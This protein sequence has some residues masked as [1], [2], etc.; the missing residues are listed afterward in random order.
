MKKPN[1]SFQKSIENQVFDILM[2]EGKCLLAAAP[3]SGKSKM[4]A[5]IIKKFKASRKTASK[6]VAFTHGSKVLQKQF[7]SDL[8]KQGVICGEMHDG[9]NITVTLPHATRKYKGKVDLLIVDEAHHFYYANMI[10]NFIKVVKPKYIL[11]MTGSPGIF[12][13]TNDFKAVY[14]PTE[15]LLSKSVISNPDIRLESFNLDIDLN[16]YEDRTDSLERSFRFKQSQVSKAIRSIDKYKGK[17]IIVC[18]DI[19]HL[20]Q[21]EKVLDK[22]NHSYVS[23][24]YKNDVSSSNIERFRSDKTRY[25]LV[26]K[27][28]VLGFSMDNL[29]NIIDFSGSM[30]I[31]FLFQLINRVTRLGFGKKFIKICEKNMFDFHYLSLNSACALVIREYY[32]TYTPQTVK[33]MQ[34]PIDK[35]VLR[36]IKKNARKENKTSIGAFTVDIEFLIKNHENKNIYAYSS[37]KKIRSLYASNTSFYTI[38]SASK[39]AKSCKTP[40]DFKRKHNGAYQFMLRDARE[41]YY[42]IFPTEEKLVDKE[43]A[44]RAAKSFSSRSEMMGSNKGRVVYNAI[45]RYKALGDLDK[46]F[47]DKK[48]HHKKSLSD[49]LELA[50]SFGDRNKFMKKHS[51]YYTKLRASPKFKKLLDEMYPLKNTKN[52]HGFTKKIIIELAKK[53]E[54]RTEFG[55]RHPFANT[56]AYQNKIHLKFKSKYKKRTV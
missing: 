31:D 34:L 53:C 54:H 18:K 26:V 56:F 5:H 29:S 4:A 47:P 40:N 36:D 35:S 16:N 43:S 32:E 13:A 46:I 2:K 55:S 37:I 23:S 3:A 48:S 9:D 21:V 25:L 44:L 51:Y 41:E 15:F 50:R 42:L 17:T 39:L 14:V 33:N 10:Q 27:R 11:V 24:Y 20:R 38:E 45:C 49:L 12:N 1:Y 8:K 52:P 6:I 22:D 19:A 28:A 7:I 30:N